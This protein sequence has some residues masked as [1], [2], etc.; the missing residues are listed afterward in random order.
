MP[1]HIQAKFGLETDL[2]VA[3]DGLGPRSLA[4]CAKVKNL[5]RW[6]AL[7]EEGRKTQQQKAL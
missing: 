7:E 4:P 1:S 6:L 3:S 2:L 5:T